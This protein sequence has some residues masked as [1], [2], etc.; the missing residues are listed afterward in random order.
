MSLSC[1]YCLSRAA[2]SGEHILQSCLG[3]WRQ[4]YGIV[5]AECNGGFSGHSGIDTDLAD[6]FGVLK[7]LLWI[8]DGRGS[9]SP[10][11]R[12]RQAGKAADG[13]ALDLLPGGRFAPTSTQQTVEG[14]AFNISFGSAGQ[15]LS[16]FPHLERQYGDRLQSLSI[17]TGVQREGAIQVPL[18]RMPGERGMR[19][20]SKSCFNFLGTVLPVTAREAI[21]DS[22]RRYVLE[23]TEAGRIGTWVDMISPLPFDLP[24]PAH[25]IFV[26]SSSCGPALAAQVQLFGVLQFAVVLCEEYQGPPVHSLFVANPWDRSMTVTPAP[27][28]RFDL[29][30]ATSVPREVNIERVS[31]AVSSKLAVAVNS[32]VGHTRLSENIIRGCQIAGL[33][34]GD[35]MRGNA[36]EVAA[37]IADEAARDACGLPTSYTVDSPEEASRRESERET[38]LMKWARKAPWWTGVG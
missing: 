11:P 12:V 37:K 18:V 2:A 8:F 25:A 16:R 4:S 14:S 21:F 34:E 36:R 13:R 30:A 24:V 28:H 31:L 35:D 26:S 5:C 38:L 22:L 20:I 29:D 3:S 23:G 15:A 27:E 6:C 7:C 10:P 33:R 32:V 1:I 17:S 9:G 19:A